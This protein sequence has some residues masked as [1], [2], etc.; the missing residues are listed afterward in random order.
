MRQ[1]TIDPGV[2]SIPDKKAAPRTGMRTKIMNLAV[3]CAGH[4]ATEVLA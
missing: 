1:R 3:K 2:Q 4:S